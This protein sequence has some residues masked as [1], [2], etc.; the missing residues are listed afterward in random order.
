MS[1]WMPVKRSTAR[2]ADSAAADESDS[3]LAYEIVVVGTSW[4][5]LAALKRIVAE[6]PPEY[7]LPTVIVQHRHRDSDALLARFLQDQTRLSVCEIEDKQ[8]VESGRLFVAPS[9]YHVLVERGYFALSLEAPVRFSRPSIDATF[10]S[11]ADAYGHRCV[12]IV[13]TGAND[14]GA[15]GLRRVADAGGLA[16]VQDPASAEC[17]VMPESALRAVPTARVLPLDRIGPFLGQLPTRHGTPG[18]A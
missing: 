2:S 3:T 16:V 15:D 6:M 1:A 5:G 10:S 7:D 12:G 14:D 8:P 4:G 17:A 9:N 18:P 13:L 11:A